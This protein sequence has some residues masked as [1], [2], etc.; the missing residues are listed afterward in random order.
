MKQDSYRFMGDLYYSR[1][2]DGEGPCEFCGTD[3]DGSPERCFGH[4]DVTYLDR[5]VTAADGDAAVAQVEAAFRRDRALEG[6]DIEINEW[7][8]RTTGRP[9]TEVEPNV[10][11]L[12]QIERDRQALADWKAG[13]PIVGGEVVFALEGER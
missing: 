6:W 2:W 3:D 12:S 1:V 13:L 4:A 7:T 9:V 5:I 10:T 8:Y 11:N